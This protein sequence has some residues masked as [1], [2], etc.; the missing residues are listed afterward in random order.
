MFQTA[1]DKRF[2]YIVSGYLRTM[3]MLQVYYKHRLWLKETKVE[4]TKYIKKNTALELLEL[5]SL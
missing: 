5:F 3:F 1:L 2:I 4:I